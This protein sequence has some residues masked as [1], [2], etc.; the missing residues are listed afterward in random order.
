L[1]RLQGKVALITGGAGGIGSAT[2]ERFAAEGA[3]VVVADIKDDDAR[4]VAA[5]IGRG[6]VAI[7]Y[8][9]GDDASV[10]DGIDGTAARFGRLDIL[11]NNHAMLSGGQGHDSDVIGTELAVWEKSLSVSLTGYF[12]GCKYAVPHMIAA[13]GGSIINMTSTSALTSNYTHVAYGAAKAGVIA[14]TRSVAA[15]HGR[16]GVRCN[17]IAP[18]L[19]VTPNV[20]AWAPD[21]IE[22]VGRYNMVREHG[23]PADIAALAAFLAADESRFITAQVINCDGGLIAQHPQSVDMAQ[24]AERKAR[25]D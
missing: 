25:R 21:L 13:G 17:A 16:A 2:A 14:L 20:R 3:Q 23:E 10:R 4:A 12:L 6:A 11:H 19:I 24:Y 9:G 1:N 18:G 7:Y 22:I 8:D 15:N 5:A